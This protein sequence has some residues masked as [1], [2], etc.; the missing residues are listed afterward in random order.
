MGKLPDREQGEGGKYFA[1]Q[2]VYLTDPKLDIAALL[3]KQV[4]LV[5]LAALIVEELMPDAAL[6]F[7]ES[8]DLVVVPAGYALVRGESPGEGLHHEK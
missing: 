5:T 1:K 3:A 7:E 6:L 4:Q 8:A 2:R